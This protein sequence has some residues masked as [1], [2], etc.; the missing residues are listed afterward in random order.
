MQRLGQRP[1]KKLASLMWLAASLAE[2]QWCEFTSSTTSASTSSASC[3]T[4]SNW[5]SVCSSS[6]CNLL[7]CAFSCSTSCFTAASYV[8]ATFWTCTYDHQRSSGCV[9]HR[10]PIQLIVT[11]G[12]EAPNALRN[13]VN[14]LLRCTYCFLLHLLCVLSSALQQTARPYAVLLISAGERIN[15]CFCYEG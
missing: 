5:P 4:T 10:Q 13:Y 9:A 1:M 7:V 14:Q 3:R 2:R 6:A 15:L 8:Q 11:C 12:H